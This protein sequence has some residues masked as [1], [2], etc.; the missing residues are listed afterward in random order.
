VVA[1]IAWPA[2]ARS[3][4]D[5]LGA[6][7]GRVALVVLGEMLGVV[8][9]SAPRRPGLALRPFGGSVRWPAAAGH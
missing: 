3:L 9:H 5:E 4:L 1:D 8:G 2:A 7:P 6:I